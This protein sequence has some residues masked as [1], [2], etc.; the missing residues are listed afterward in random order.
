MVSTSS[1]KVTNYHRLARDQ[2]ILAWLTVLF[3][4]A[5]VAL[6][7]SDTSPGRIVVGAISIAGMIWVGLYLAC[8]VAVGVIAS[9]LRMKPAIVLLIGIL[10]FVPFVSLLPIIAVQAR[11]N[12]FWKS[13]GLRPTVF[14][15][16][17]AM[18]EG[19]QHGT[20]CAGCGYNLQGNESGVC[21]ECGRAIGLAAE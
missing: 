15:V 17:P 9:Q 10:A 3:A 11:L 21:P 5:H 16:D 12:R 14:G 7:F 6:L 13:V 18:A 20:R 1:N 4:A 19:L 2:R 8:A